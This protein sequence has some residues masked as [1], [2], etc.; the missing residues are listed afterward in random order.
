M[1][2]YWDIESYDNLFCSGFIDDN[3]TLEMHYLVT[4]K[5]DEQEVLRACEDSGYSYK[6][7]DLSKD[8]S[9]LLWHMQERIPS[10]GSDSLLANFLGLTEEEVKPKEDV[11][12]AYNSLSYDIQMMDFFKKSVV[13]NRTQTTPKRLRDFSDTLIDGTAKRVGTIGYEMYANQVD[14]GYLNEAMIENGRIMIGLKTLVGML[15]GSIIESDSNKTGHSDDIYGDVL[16]NINDISEM[17]DVVYK[18]TRLEVTQTIRE[19]L[20]KKYESLSRK[21]ISVNASSAK[22]VENI[23][24]PDKPIVDNPTVSYMYPA[25]HIA[26]EK[27]IEPFDMLEYFKDWYMTN[28]YEV[29]KKHNPKVAEEHRLKFMSIYG[30]YDAFRGKNWNDSSSHFLRYQIP[31]QPKTARRELLDTF[32]T[33]IPFIDKYG[34]DSGTHL[35]FSAGGIHGAE[36]FEEQL[37]QDRAKIKEIRER[38]K[39]ISCIPKSTVSQSLMNIIKLQS[40]TPI[41][42]YPNRLLHEIPHLY[43]QS[44]QSDNILHED[45]LSPFMYMPSKNSEKLIERYKYTS[46]GHMLHQDF[47]GYYPMLLI[48]LGVFYDGNGTDVY[49]EI[50]NHRIRV[51]NKLKTLEKGT[52]EW[53]AVNIEQE[54]YKLILNSASGVLDGSFDTNVRANNKAL[55]MRAIGQMITAIIGFALALEGAVIPS[56]NTDGIYVHSISKELNEEILQRELQKLYVT[57]DPEEL[58]LVSKDTNNRLE[59]EGDKVVNAKGGTLT[60]SEGARVDKRLSHPALCDRILVQYLQHDNIVNQELQ[61]DVIRQEMLN[62][63][64]QVDRRTF[65]HMASWV[66]RSTSQSVFID[67]ENNLYKGTI[68]VWLTKNGTTLKRYSAQKMKPEKAFRTY[69]ETLPD[70]A[71]IGEPSTVTKLC[72]L[73]DINEIWS[74]WDGLLTP[75]QFEVMEQHADLTGEALPSLPALKEVKIAKLADNVKVRIDNRS[76]HKM[77]DDEVDEL[78]ESLDFEA[79]VQM[80]AETTLKWRNVLKAS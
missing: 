44:E 64:R 62:Y 41:E 30:F 10:L 60:S 18:H 37:Q 65:I 59:M 9:R 57:I 32:G 6:A 71:P 39:F 69:L 34:N 25:P 3:D 55:A 54:G 38:Y 23:V 11:Y 35:N 16:Y 50:Y 51:K 2:Y 61:E 7:Y 40:R 1:Q 47:A 46:I 49:H 77:T 74:R 66:M 43:K 70:D 72:S 36:T 73:M 68:R 4:S 19:A 75:K 52:P 45:D 76:I 26:K 56:S 27:G 12:I 17:K 42:G 58:Y 80:I 31:A 22:F 78:Y 5:E 79:Y 48:N 28:V 14:A 13:A 33:Y 8:A 24:A 53:E 29:V 15:G 67:E 21:N 63:I 20:I